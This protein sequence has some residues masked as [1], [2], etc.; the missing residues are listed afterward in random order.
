M[1][2]FGVSLDWVQP[3]TGPVCI[4]LFLSTVCN[5]GIPA[6][7]VGEIPDREIAVWTIGNG[8]PS[9][10]ASAR[11]LQLPDFELITSYG[12]DGVSVCVSEIP[13][14]RLNLVPPI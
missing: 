8:P 2:P 9:A 11:L 5:Q 6:S 13:G 12:T 10:R 4:L 1:A 7:C 3:Q 14:F